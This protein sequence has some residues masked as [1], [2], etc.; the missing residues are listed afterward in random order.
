MRTRKMTTGAAIECLE[1]R[2][3]LSVTVSTI[4]ADVNAV[5]SAGTTLKAAIKTAITDLVSSIPA[6]TPGLSTLNADLTT[7][8]SDLQTADTTLTDKLNKLVAGAG[9]P[10]QAGLV[11]KLSAAANAA[12]TTLAAD[13]SAIKSV[14][15]KHPAL[16]AD[17]THLTADEAAVTSAY[18]TEKGDVKTLITD[19]N[20]LT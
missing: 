5:E 14:L 10:A 1:S 6:G 18:D 8:K 12:K 7:F 16:I 2:R 19:L 4:Q 3:L 17:D 9:S 15:T 11:S 20:N 13:A